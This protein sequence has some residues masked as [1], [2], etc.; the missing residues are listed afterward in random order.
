MLVSSSIEL[1]SHMWSEGHQRHLVLTRVTRQL[2]LTV[3]HR[4]LRLSDLALARSGPVALQV[5]ET[6]SAAP[7]KRAWKSEGVPRRRLQR[8][9]GRGPVRCHR[10]LAKPQTRPAKEKPTAQ[11]YRSPC[12]NGSR[13]RSGLPLCET[14]RARALPKPRRLSKGTTV[15]RAC[16]VIGSIGSDYDGFAR[17]PTTQLT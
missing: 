6:R 8:I 16:V 11:E 2:R 5:N 13:W 3:R 17:T 9:I 12:M 4:Q 15:G 7:D 1:S 14:G 10:D